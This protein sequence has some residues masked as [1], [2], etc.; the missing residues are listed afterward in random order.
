M[1]RPIPVVK[2]RL[3]I[4]SK[5]EDRVIEALTRIG[6]V[7]VSKPMVRKEMLLPAPLRRFLERKEISQIGELNEILNSIRDL[8]VIVGE[9]YY[10][11]ALALVRRIR[12]VETKISLVKFLMELGLKPGDLGRHE[13]VFVYGGLIPEERLDIVVTQLRA[14]HVVCSTKKLSDESVLLVI[15]GPIIHEEKALDILG[16]NGFKEVDIRECR[17]LSCEEALNILEDEV[18]KLYGNLLQLISDIAEEIYGKGG[19]ETTIIDLFLSYVREF[20]DLLRSIRETLVRAGVKPPTLLETALRREVVAQTIEF[21]R[22]TDIVGDL[23]ASMDRYR[24]E[25]EKLRSLI[26]I[27]PPPKI[28]VREYS[29]DFVLRELGKIREYV[30]KAIER[31]R[32]I[33][34]LI[35]LSITSSK[36]FMN[37]YSYVPYVEAVCYLREGISYI[38]IYRRHYVAIAEGWIPRSLINTFKATVRKLI[39]KIISLT[40]I[41][42]R[43]GEKVPILPRYRGVLRYFSQLTMVRGVP[44]YWELDPTLIFTSLFIIMYGMMFGDMGLGPIISLIGYLLYKFRKPIL[45]ISGSSMRILG[46]ILIF[47]GISSTLFGLFYGTAFLAEVCK[48][49]FISPLHDINELIKVSI[50]FGIVQIVIGIVINITNSIVEKD[51]YRAFLCN[52][53]LVALVYYVS[54]VTLV[55]AIIKNNYNF[56]IAFT[57]LYMIPSTLVLSSMV[58]VLIGPITK[59]FKGEAGIGE[60]LNEGIA[61]LLELI[62]GYLANTISYV[63]LAAFALAHEALGMAAGALSGLIGVI[64]SYVILNFVALGLEGVVVGIQSLRLIYYEFSTKFYRGDGVMY[65]PVLHFALEKLI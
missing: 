43:V 1:L 14:I 32:A 27:P 46:V 16:K 39:P 23:R 36:Y 62:I 41:N 13:Y 50:L 24:S 40:F 33:K 22:L 56:N 7:H 55:Y 25:Y 60:C 26:E 42:P 52:K 48:P 4:D 3:I 19:A 21:S 28:V 47:C 9:G 31:R 18:R 20:E 54:G 49:L 53:G 35:E 38:R 64:P 8:S 51:Y 44:S 37:V 6:L 11:Q 59:Y 58:I 45:G 10:E 63:R 12:S 29:V 5:Y 30:E 15:V 2:F 65:K 61:E 57:G 17:K 34:K